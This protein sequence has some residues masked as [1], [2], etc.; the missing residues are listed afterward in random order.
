MQHVEL[1]FLDSGTSDAYL[2]VGAF[3]VEGEVLIGRAPDCSLKPVCTLVSRYH[4]LLINDVDKLTITD[5]NS[6][7][8]T[9]VNGEKLRAHQPITLSDGDIVR[10]G[11]AAF[12]VAIL[13]KP[14]E[15]SKSATTVFQGETQLENF[16]KL[17][18]AEET[19]Q[20]EADASV[21]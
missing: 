20:A 18:P 14:N 15:E 21:D 11:T 12:Q 9:F 10:T 2:M 19:Q 1:R 17:P 3:A 7:N 6:T 5:L 16:P 4:C 13:A 8:G